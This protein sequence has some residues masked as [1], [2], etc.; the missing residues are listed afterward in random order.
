MRL[1]TVESEEVIGWIK[2]NRRPITVFTLGGE[3]CLIVSYCVDRK[4]ICITGSNGKAIVVDE[5]IW[6][7]VVDYIKGL[8]DE[9]SLKSS[10]YARPNVVTKKLKKVSNFNPAIPAICKAY[11]AY[12]K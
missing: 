9:D 3:S 5:T 1:E 11:W 8:S 2:K 4:A 12:H 10:S 7:E 6:Q